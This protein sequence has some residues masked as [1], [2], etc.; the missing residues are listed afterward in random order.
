MLQRD[1]TQ[2]QRL[3]EEAVRQLSAPMSASSA[4]PLDNCQLMEAMNDNH[5][6]QLLPRLKACDDSVAAFCQRCMDSKVVPVRCAIHSDSP[7][8]LYLSLQELS[9]H[10]SAA[11]G[12]RPG[13]HCKAQ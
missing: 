7:Q 8:A 5:I 4:S 11:L 12:S 2:V 10:H 1:C 13:P 6:T 3:V 9:V